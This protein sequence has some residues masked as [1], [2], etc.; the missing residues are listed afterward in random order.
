MPKKRKTV[1]VEPDVHEF[2]S[3]EGR[4]ASETVNKLVRK[5]MNGE[6]L[7]EE[8]LKMRIEQ[9]EREYRQKANQTREALEHLNNLRK[10]LDKHQERQKQQLEE[11]AA[12]VPVKQLRSGIIIDADEPVL[13]SYADSAGVD[14]DELREEVMKLN[15]GEND[16]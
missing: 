8:L 12:D 2:L 1:S 13:E 14:V 16:G 4:N 6:G 5:E 9:A 11:I 10:R 15:S 3:E 7:S